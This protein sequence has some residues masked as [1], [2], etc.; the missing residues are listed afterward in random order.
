MR[1]GEDWGLCYNIKMLQIRK[2]SLDDLDL[3]SCFVDWWLAGRGKSKGVPGATNDYFISKGQHKKYITKYT[4]WLCFDE[5]EMI[6]WAVVEPSGTLI[7]MLICG[8]RRGEGIGRAL[9]D[10]IKPKYVR[11]K[12]DQSSGNPI[13]F[14]EK[15]GYQLVKKVRSQGR[16]DIDR[17]RPL[18]KQNIDILELAAD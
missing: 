11:S 14:Y 8:K 1:L 17:I 7:N 12:S 9:M 4:T 2:A 13:V 5:L 18:R 16:L 6:G 10:F 3:V 15:M